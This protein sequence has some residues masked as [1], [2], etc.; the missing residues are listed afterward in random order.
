MRKSIIESKPKKKDK[1]TVKPLK[2]Q[3]TKFSFKGGK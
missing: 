3:S 2:S 1:K